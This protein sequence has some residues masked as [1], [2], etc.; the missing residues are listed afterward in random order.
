MLRRFTQNELYS[1]VFHMHRALCDPIIIGLIKHSISVTTHTKVDIFGQVWKKLYNLRL[2]TL[3]GWCTYF[4]SYMII[5]LGATRQNCKACLCHRGLQITDQFHLSY[6]FFIYIAF[7][8]KLYFI[9]HSITQ[10]TES[11]FLEWFCIEYNPVFQSA[12][13]AS[14][15]RA[16][17]QPFDILDQ[18]SG[19]TF[20]L[21]DT[22]TWLKALAI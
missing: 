16:W 22:A 3:K 18:K 6:F 21:W 12:S 17:I 19:L 20:S 11:F 8:N 2:R 7:N 14:W 13:K 4:P 1:V 10:L 9:V 15:S 5:W